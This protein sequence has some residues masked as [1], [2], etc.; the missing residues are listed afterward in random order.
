MAEIELFQPE[1]VLDIFGSNVG[2]DLTG[3][4]EVGGQVKSP[5]E[6]LT[7]GTIFWKRLPYVFIHRPFWIMSLEFGPHIGR[8]FS[9]PQSVSIR[10]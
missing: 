9:M 1:L 7:K 8:M 2:G 10:L 6:A 3:E 4:T 5:V